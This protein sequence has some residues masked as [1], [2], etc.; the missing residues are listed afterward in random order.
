MKR[1]KKKTKINIF[2]LTNKRIS[3]KS[4]LRN[5]TYYVFKREG[6]N[7]PNII[8]I[9]I[10]DARYL[11]DLN[12]K[13]FGRNRTTNVISFNLGEIGEIY[14]SIDEVRQPKDLYYYLVHGLLHI[15]GYDHKTKRAEILMARKCLGYTEKFLGK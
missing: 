10:A 14:I 6:L 15:F 13:F 4:K 3:N 11:K 2:N 8:N 5:F 7:N 1:G 12:K 9:I